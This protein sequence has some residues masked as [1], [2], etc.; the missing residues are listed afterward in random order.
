M[1]PKQ[2]LT[3][4]RYRL[5]PDN[6]QLWFGKRLVRLTRKAFDVLYLLVSHPGQLVTKDALLAAV[7]P[8]V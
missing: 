5:D 4:G 6:V 2:H 3:F 8:E 1:S 7:W